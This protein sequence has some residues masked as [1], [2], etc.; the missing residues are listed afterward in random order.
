METALRQNK[1]FKQLLWIGIGS[2]VMFFGG[3]TSAYIVRKAEGNWLEFEMPIWFTLST[4][5]VI[6]SSISSVSY[7]H[8]TLPTI[9]LV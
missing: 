9:L 3:L 2:I 4:I 6:V 1:T 5:A 7:T 8:L